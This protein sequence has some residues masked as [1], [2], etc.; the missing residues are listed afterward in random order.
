[1]SNSFPL[2]LAWGLP[3]CC[4]ATSATNKLMCGLTSPQ[5][6]H[7]RNKRPVHGVSFTSLPCLSSKT[8]RMA[9]ACLLLRFLRHFV[10][11]HTSVR[12]QSFSFTRGLPQTESADGPAR[13]RPLALTTPSTPAGLAV[14]ENCSFG[15]SSLD[16]L[17]MHRVVMKLS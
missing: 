12:T 16:F 1:M 17:A 2:R 4:C 3:H 14:A 10:C 13:D 15:C 8:S 5:G 7:T 6:A 9:I 11:N